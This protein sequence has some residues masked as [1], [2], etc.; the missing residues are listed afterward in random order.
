[1]LVRFGDMDGFSRFGLARG[2]PLDDLRREMDRLLFD[3]ERGA[4]AEPEGWP[5][6]SA[7]DRGEA[8]FVRAEVPGLTDKDIELTATATSFSLRGERKV[9]AP[10][11]YATHRGERRGFRFAR[12][13]NL[14]TKIDPERVAAS[15]ENGVL[16][17]TLPKAAEAKPKQI[18]V[19]A[20]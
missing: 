1:M 13:F 3:F 2:F 4:P 18:T 9:E 19:K 11:G 6:I 7:E 16:T 15:L 20:S 5:K 12:T 17:V 14:G 8:L 10:E